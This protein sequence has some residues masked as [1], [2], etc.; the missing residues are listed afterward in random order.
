MVFPGKYTGVM[1]ET[2]MITTLDY[3][4]FEK[5]CKKLS[6][7][8]DTEFKDITNS[9]NFTRITISDVDFA[10]KNQGNFLSLSV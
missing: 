8:A 6:E 3:R 7:W 2:G 5:A 1:E 10:K 4:M 9:C